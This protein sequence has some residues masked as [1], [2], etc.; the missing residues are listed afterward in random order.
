MIRLFG[1]RRVGEQAE[2]HPRSKINV[3]W[4]RHGVAFIPGP[5]DEAWLDEPSVFGADSELVLLLRQL[6]E[7]GYIEV[8][9]SGAS[10]GWESYYRLEAVEGYSASLHLLK[11]PAKRG[12][13][14][15]LSS[16]GG[17]SDA[18]FAIGISG[19]RD[20]AGA[21]PSGNVEIQGAI[22]SADGEQSLLSESVWRVV[23]AIAERRSRS[24]EGYS[25]EDNKRDWARIRRH[26]IDANADLADFLAKTIVL[27]PERIDIQMRKGGEGAQD[28]VEIMPGFD[29]APSRWLEVFDRFEVVPERYEIPNGAGLVHVLMSEDA[30]AVLSEI[31]RM[32]G[33]RVAGARAEAFLRNPFATLGPSAAVAIDP[34]QFERA[35]EDAGIVFERFSARVVADQ[36]GYPCDVG[37]LIE[38]VFEGK[39]VAEESKFESATELGSFIAKMEQRFATGAQCCHWKGFDLEILGDSPDQVEKLRSA[40]AKLA[41]PRKITVSDIFDLSLYSERIEGFGVEKPYYS[42]FIAK[43]GDGGWV[44]ENV[45]LGLWF[46]DSKGETVAIPLDGRNLDKFRKEVEQAEQEKR[47]SFSFPGCPRPVPTGWAKEALETLGKVKEEVKGGNYIPGKDKSARKMVERKGLVVKPNVDGLDYEERRGDLSADKAP[48]AIPSSLRPDIEL[49]DHQRDGLAWLQNMWRNSPSVCRG[50]LL[51]DDMG[52]GKTVQLLAF[53]ASLIELEPRIDPFLVVAPVS[54][55]DNWKAEIE[56]F[57]VEGAMDVLTLYGPNLAAKRAPR[58][59][60]DDGL[61]ESGSP[62]LL[63]LDWLGSANVVLTTYETLRDLEF[64]LAAQK[65][66]VMVCDEAQKIKNPNAM[67]TRAAKKQNA[68]LKIACTGTPVENTLADL[69]CLFDFV[70]P[71]LLGSLKDFGSKYRRP[72]EVETDDEKA[73]IEE[74][75]GLIEPQKLRRTKAEVA[76]DL[77]KKILHEGC[78][79]LPLSAR[80]R[81]LYADAVAQFKSRGQGQGSGL[82]SPLGLLQYLRRLCSDPR[83]PGHIATSD[84]SVETIKKASP[85][86]DWMLR[87]LREI[88]ASGAG[89]KV[90]VFCEF[91]DLQRVI[92]RAISE[93]FGFVPD[94]INGDTST[95]SGAASSRQTRITA[96]QQN[97][98]F[99]VIILSPLAV[100]FGVNIQAANH[101]IHYTRTWNPAKE[102][103]AT[104]RAYRIGQQKDV[105]VYY[106]VVVGGDF[107]TFDEKLDVLLER[108]RALSY[109]MLN[110]VGDVTPSDFADIEAPGG[111]SPFG[112]DLFNPVDVGSLGPDAFESFCALLWSKQGYSRTIK[113]PKTGDGGVD[114]VAIKGNRG[115]L[116]QCKS[117][118]VE[119]KEMGWEAVKDVAAGSVAYS[120]RYPGVEFQLIAAT[121]R[122]FNQSARQQASLLNV[123][124]IEGSDLVDLLSKHPTKR[125]EFDR[126]AMAGWSQ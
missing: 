75:R 29:G 79:K 21:Q 11:L 18:T 100:G 64:S 31:R 10:M 40:L 44:P 123:T 91:R 86:M 102:D 73:R 90:I 121:N 124:L 32:P 87:R 84:E 85:K 3:S 80:Q 92:Q 2:V 89:D 95:E 38:Q 19:W 47:E 101:V 39:L 36:S 13:R 115:A 126:F 118:G 4:G 72:I 107:V 82:Q 20:P 35:R 76:K 104:D 66:S 105:Y 6:E 63:A 120:A 7:E 58:S 50:A 45:D 111:G 97:P 17:L 30:R 108:K 74:L 103:Q 41:L 15:M 51:A 93:V 125:G 26:A 42:P 68:R 81:A 23:H 62:K 114:I 55:L 116:I 16:R 70:Q 61:I 14:P 109:D 34:D 69:W 99:G 22:V 117:S 78:R 53:M 8:R 43:K 65:W 28:M 48:P 1:S 98:G 83:P 54:L 88:E 59:A 96:Y 122:R 52:L 77:P 12:W 27:T 57:F 49:K 56:K 94:V 112:E 110:G 24:A 106:P 71:G 33:R 119:G 46:T 60:L 37:L 67:V 113:T 5:A 25:P 9:P